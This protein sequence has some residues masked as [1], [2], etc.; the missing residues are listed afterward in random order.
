MGFIAP[1]IAIAAQVFS[2]FAGGGGG[3][4][5]PPPIQSFPSP[6]TEDTAAVRR[7]A[8]E[9][10]K[11]RA[12][13]KGLSST[14]LT[15]GVIYYFLNPYEEEESNNSGSGGGGGDYMEEDHPFNASCS[16]VYVWD[17]DTFDGNSGIGRVRLADI[18]CP[19]DDPP[20]KN[21]LI[22]LIYDK[23]VYLDID[24]NKDPYDRWIA[25][26]YVRYNSTHL[27]NVNKK[28]VD[29]GHAV[30]DDY[31]NNFNPYTWETFY[32]YEG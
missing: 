10:R 5:A 1:I 32:Y 14:I 28:M 12:K 19:E 9:E 8:E 27:L 30:I 15:G 20:S 6:P 3:R 31:P 13:A 25:V 26:T 11:R 21:Y 24:P 18:D 17:G 23:K 4:G 2:S 7:R 22:S 16:C 29:S